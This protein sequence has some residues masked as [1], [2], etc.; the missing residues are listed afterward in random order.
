M[1]DIHTHI[2]PM[3]DDGA[4]SVEEALDMLIE[5]YKDGT[6][7]V[8]LTP[9][10]AY[11]YGFENSYSKIKELYE[12]LKYIIEQEGIP[13][14]VYLGTEFL[15]SSKETFINALNDI[16]KMNQTN[17][18]LMEFY[19][20]IEFKEILEAIDTVNEYG[21]IPIIA[22]PERYDCVQENVYAPK[23]MVKHGALLQMN[24]GSVL[25][26]YGHYARETALDMLND[27]Y[28]SF[29][30][31]D[32]HSLRLRTPLMYE[33]YHYV[34]V[35]Y[36]KEYADDIFNNNAEKMLENIDIRKWGKH[37]EK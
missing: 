9:H 23:E 26:R 7:A 1:I 15:F 11:A 19:F 30:G 12:D 20:D 22:H 31:S 35:E 3:I 17:Y 25:G 10:L 4:K 32:A 27:Q 33:C 16:T 8:V 21:Y 6:D 2:L 18:I 29:V 37:E 36:G 13:L 28:V 5:A 24:K 14:R 34:K